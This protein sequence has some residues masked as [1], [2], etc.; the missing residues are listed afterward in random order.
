MDDLRVV[1]NENLAL[2]MYVMQL[3]HVKSIDQ[4]DEVFEEMHT[5]GE[6]LSLNK[7]SA[8]DEKDEKKIKSILKDQLKNTE[9]VKKSLAKSPEL[10]S[11][12][13]QTSKIK[14]FQDLVR[15]TN[16]EKEVELKY[17]LERNVRVLS[18]VP[19]KINITF[20]EKLNKNFIKILTEKLL[21]W[22]GERWI[23]SLSKQEGEETIFEKTQLDKK[24]K[25]VEA[26]KSEIVKNVLSV[27]PD[28][29]LIDITEEND[30]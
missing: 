7:V 3:M 14:T 24:N 21:K 28:A 25:L 10:K 16:E 23:I 11:K 4:R 13:L 5:N 9:Q 2:E 30:A 18:F 12:P 1:G 20:N 15:T 19:G 17:D 22:T 29:K 6:S 27:F 26:K 8:S